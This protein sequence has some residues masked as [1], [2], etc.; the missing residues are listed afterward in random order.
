MPVRS[1]TP[2]KTTARNANE[3]RCRRVMGFRVDTLW[4]LKRLT[5]STS[6]DREEGSSE[7]LGERALFRLM[8]DVLVSCV[9]ERPSWRGRVR[10]GQ[11]GGVEALNHSSV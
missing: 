2:T 10:A 11:L 3:T 6:G 9:V 7:C 1:W 4:A 5:S 8:D